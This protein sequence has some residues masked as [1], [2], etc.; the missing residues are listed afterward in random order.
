MADI[1]RLTAAHVQAES[2]ALMALLEDA[3]N[4]GASVGFLRPL[5]HDLCRAY[6]DEVGAAVAGGGRILLA[7]REAGEIVG[8]VQLDLSPKQNGRHRAEVQKLL[9]LARWRRRGIARHLMRA[10]EDQAR[11]AGRSLLVLDTES[12]SAAVAFYDS[13]GWERCGSIPD[14]ALSADGVPTANIL[15]YK[16]VP[17]PRRH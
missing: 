8:S 10:I 16:R 4:H 11:A 5:D 17:A 3:V 12:G 13:L 1:V 9:V 14:F 7:A 15:Y 2:A 6:W